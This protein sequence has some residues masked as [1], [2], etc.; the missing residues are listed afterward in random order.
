M[1]G[2]RD[3]PIADLV[4]GMGRVLPLCSADVNVPKAAVLLSANFG[5]IQPVCSAPMTV[6]PGRLAVTRKQTVAK[7]RW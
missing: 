2:F 7:V 5:Q 6:V 1:S 4:T 3:F